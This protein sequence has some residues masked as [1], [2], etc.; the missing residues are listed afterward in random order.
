VNFGTTIERAFATNF[1]DAIYGNSA[2]N[3]LY[4]RSGNDF[5]DGLDG[6]DTA[7]YDS[8]HQDYLIRVARD[9]LV[10]ISDQRMF[11]QVVGAYQGDGVDSLRNIESLQFA[12]QP[13]VALMRLL[14]LARLDSDGYE[15]KIQAYF[16]TTL[17]RSANNIEL[18]SFQIL[19]QKHSG[20]V[21]KADA[22]LRSDGHSLVS[23]LASLPDF[24]QLITNKNYEDLVSEMYN[25]MTGAEIEETLLGYYSKQLDLGGIK[26]RGLANAFLN[27]LSLMPRI[28]N[29]LSQPNGWTVNFFDQL[30]PEDFIGYL[31]NLELVG[32]D[33]INLDAGGNFG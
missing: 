20:N 24:T 13:A 11:T 8:V 3:L 5:L 23:Y 33:V 4:G 22:A 2:D 29:T 16:I 30:R 19:L 10:T 7:R 18:Q 12:D 17:G 27:D 14:P 31:E 32:V 9:G 28:D 25:R 6:H 1:A 15:A 21:W 26:L